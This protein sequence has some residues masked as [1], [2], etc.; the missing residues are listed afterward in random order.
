MRVFFGPPGFQYGPDPLL[1]NVEKTAI[2]VGEGI[3]YL[4]SVLSLIVRRICDTLALGIVIRDVGDRQSA[5]CSHLRCLHCI[6]HVLKILYSS[7]DVCA[8]YARS[9][10]CDRISLAARRSLC[11]PP[12]RRVGVTP[13][14]SRQ[15]W[16]LCF[17]VFVCVGVCLCLFVCRCEPQRISVGGPNTRDF[18]LFLFIC[19]CFCLFILLCVFL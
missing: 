15:P 19:V 12:L 11:E 3:S 18:G 6:D 2:L 1:N 9:L 14:G 16:C 17:S 4:E 5:V 13:G 7:H 8:K 10:C